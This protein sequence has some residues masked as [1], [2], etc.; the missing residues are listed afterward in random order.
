MT[1]RSDSAKGN[2]EKAVGTAAV[3]RDGVAGREG[4]AGRRQLAAFRIGR[5]SSSSAAE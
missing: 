4:V 2:G 5:R 3:G 1:E